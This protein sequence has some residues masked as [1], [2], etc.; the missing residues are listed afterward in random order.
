VQNELLIPFYFVH[1]FELT[2]KCAGRVHSTA[3]Y[4][5]HKELELAEKAANFGRNSLSSIER[6]GFSKIIIIRNMVELDK[7]NNLFKKIPGD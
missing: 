5:V 6:E 1:C 2:E 3:Q 4:I 7:E